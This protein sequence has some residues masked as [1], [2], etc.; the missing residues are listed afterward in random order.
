M[1]DKRAAWG[2]KLPGGGAQ[3]WRLWDGLPGA[4]SLPDEGGVILIDGCH[5]L[6][7]ILCVWTLEAKAL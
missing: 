3:P 4:A 1:P 7:I 6:V 2:R 5:N